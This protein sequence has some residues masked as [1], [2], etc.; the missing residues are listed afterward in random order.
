MKS[1]ILEIKPAPPI[2]NG[3]GSTLGETFRS[4]WRRIL[5][6]TASRPRPLRLVENLPLGERRFVAVVEYENSRFLLG[7]TASTLVLLSQLGQDRESA[8]GSGPIE[9]GST[10]VKA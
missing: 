10:E 2:L 3:T 5:R 6:V 4:L 9:E 8:S 1:R 7:G